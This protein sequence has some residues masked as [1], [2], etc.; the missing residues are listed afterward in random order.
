VTGNRVATTWTAPGFGEFPGDARG[1]GIRAGSVT[2]TASTISGNTMNGL[3]IGADGGRPVQTT[4][5]GIF[6]LAAVTLSG[7]TV[8]DNVLTVAFASTG[9]PLSRA[10]GVSGGTVQLTGTE[11]TGNAVVDGRDPGTP[12]PDAGTLQ[13]D[14]LGADGSRIIAA[15]GQRACTAPPPAPLP[16]SGTEVSDDTCG[17]P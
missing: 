13:A 2:A 15:P 1:G 10:G 14:A 7:S 16:S 5:A 11:L 12:P 8:A 9:V 17:L 3:E 6:S 4:G